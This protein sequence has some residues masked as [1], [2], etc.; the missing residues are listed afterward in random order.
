[1]HLVRGN[2][3]VLT[4][5][6]INTLAGRGECCVLEGQ[7]IQHGEFCL[8]SRTS[9]LGAGALLS[10]DSGCLLSFDYMD[11]D[12]SLKPNYPAHFVVINGGSQV[13]TTHCCVYR[14][15]LLGGHC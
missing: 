3:T 15:S 10:C 2:L 13:L 4:V 11:L 5:D 1:M 6:L 14:M 7:L 12:I 8:S 9:K